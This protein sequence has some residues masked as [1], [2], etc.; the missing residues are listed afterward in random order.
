MYISM[1]AGSDGDFVVRICE[2]ENL[3][4]DKIYLEA[5]YPRKISSVARSIGKYE[6]ACAV[7]LSVVELSCVS[8]STFYEDKEKKKRGGG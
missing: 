3:K 5:A 6:C 4:K 7:P 2:D 1:Y 8:S